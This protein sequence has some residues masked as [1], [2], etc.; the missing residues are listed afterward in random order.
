MR[1]VLSIANRIEEGRCFSSSQ[2][3]ST[4]VPGMLVHKIVLSGRSHPTVRVHQK[5][6][7]PHI[8][9]SISYP[10][11]YLKGY[12]SRHTSGTSMG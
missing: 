5:V 3:L 12:C 4:I 10:I 9:S 8:R 2:Y 6:L 11:Q 7:S 1:N